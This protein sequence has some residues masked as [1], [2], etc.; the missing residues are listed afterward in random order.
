[1][2]KNDYLRLRKIEI[3]PS[4]AIDIN[5]ENDRIDLGKIQQYQYQKQNI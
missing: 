4:N 3:K 1:M 5:H 2:M